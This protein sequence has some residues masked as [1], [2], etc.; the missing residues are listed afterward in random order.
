MS[1]L[2]SWLRSALAIVAVT[3]GV[4]F[5]VTLF[6]PANVLDSWLIARDRDDLA[7]D[8]TVAWNHDLRPNLKMDRLWGSTH[9]P[10]RTDAHGFR[11]GE[12]ANEPAQSGRTVFVIGDSFM[13]GLGLPFEQT[14]AGVL[15]CKAKADGLAMRNLGVSSYSPI[16][17][18]RKIASA[19]ERLGVKPS[20]IVVFVDVCDMYDEVNNYVERND[21]V[22]SLLHSKQ[23]DVVTWLRHNFTS[24]AVVAELRQRYLIARPVVRDVVNRECARWT[25]DPA[26]RRAWGDRGLASAAANLEKIVKQ[27]REWNCKLDLVVYPWPDQ[28]AARD[29]DS[30][31]VRYWRDWAAKHG[32]RFINAFDL[33]FQV[34]PAEAI[35]RFYIP[36]DI[37]FNVEGSRMLAD[38][39]WKAIGK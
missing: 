21:R 6:I 38:E 3:L 12:C 8:R 2:L 23:K 15:A 5:L 36:G 28:I 29:R 22:E 13:E 19:A 25:V 39:V 17:Y 9:Y 20:E 18:H 30:I 14:I 32:V 11:T 24:F 35:R 1:R 27:C 31:H 10:Y 16:I 7:Y 4:D 37:H 33:Y 34:E 26:L